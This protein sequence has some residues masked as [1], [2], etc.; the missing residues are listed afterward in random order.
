MN[1]G[2]LSDGYKNSI[3]EKELPNGTCTKEEVALFRVHGS[4]PE[5]M[6]AIQLESY[7]SPAADGTTSFTQCPILPG[8]TFVV[9]RS[10]LIYGRGKYN[11]VT[12]GI[13]L[14]Y[15]TPGVMTARRMLSE[16]APRK[17]TGL[18]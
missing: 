17:L 1:E 15:V 7:G 6:Q 18:G 14:V 16:S 4:G 13:A 5:K 3:S 2:G 10:L 9:D 12:P 8:E 11:C